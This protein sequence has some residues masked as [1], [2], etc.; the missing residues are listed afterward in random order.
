MFCIVPVPGMVFV[1]F[2][3]VVLLVPVVPVVPVVVFVV[4]GGVC[5]VVV[6]VP[7]FTVD[8]V[9]VP[10]VVVV[11]FGFVAFALPFVAD[12]PGGQFGIGRVAGFVVG[13]VVVVVDGGVVVVGVVVCAKA[14]TAM[15]TTSPA[16]DAK[17]NIARELMRLFLLESK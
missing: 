7:L 2:I 10:L 1:Q 4:A 15:L 5:D 8:V 16:T 14:G 17:P 9:V 13:F 12:V 11:A 3:V 6:V